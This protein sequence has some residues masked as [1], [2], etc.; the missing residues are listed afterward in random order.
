ML[1]SVAGRK[2]AFRPKLFPVRLSRRVGLRR[3]Q[4]IGGKGLVCPSGE[5]ITNGGFETG[6]FTGW[7][8]S[9][10][11]IVSWGAH[12][13]TYRA[14]VETLNTPYLS[15]D[16]AN[17]VPQAC[18]TVSSVV[19]LWYKGSYDECAELGTIV[20]ARIVYTDDPETVVEH[21]TTL[22]EHGIWVE[23]DLKPYVQSGKTVK[24]L[25][26]EVD[27]NGTG[28]YTSVDDISFS[29]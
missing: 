23:I 16:L 19:S 25:R 28:A 12:S 18:L 22:A 11:S 29:V 21:E 14:W 27:D 26:I 10:F 1:K 5:Q 15:Q 13:G 9:G 2:V 7:T 17:P 4:S 20:R 8:Q 24:R 6:D 3:M